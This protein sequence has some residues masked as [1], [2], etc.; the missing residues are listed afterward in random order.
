MRRLFRAYIRL[1]MRG[2]KMLILRLSGCGKSALG[3][4]MNGL[5]PIN[6]PGKSLVDLEISGISAKYQSIFEPSRTAGAMLQDSG[7]QF[8]GHIARFGEHGGSAA[9]Y[10][11]RCGKSLECVE[12]PPSNFRDA[13]S[14]AQAPGGRQAS[15]FPSALRPH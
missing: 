15:L 13:G 4:C 9:G 7:C 12:K 8:A 11:P 1:L 2:G 6:Y 3:N 14:V 5:I 10:D